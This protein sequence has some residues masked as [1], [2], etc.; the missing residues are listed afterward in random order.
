MRT[1]LLNFSYFFRTGVSILRKRQFILYHKPTT[2]CN[3]RCEFCDFWKNQNTDAKV[4]TEDVIKML[5]DG[6]RAGLTT[7][8]LWG[9]EPLM[10][11]DLG[12]WLM[13]AKKLGYKTSMCTS[14]YLLEERHREI[15]GHIDIILLSLEDVYE[16][17]DKI[18]NT[19][20]LFER[21]IRGLEKFAGD[22]RTK[23][24]I[25]SHINKLNSLSSIDILKFA[26]RF[27]ISVEFFPSNVFSDY[28]EE[29]IFSPEERHETFS[30]IMRLKKQGW[31]V[32][33]SF[34]ALKL[35]RGDRG[36]R[37]NMA[38][39]AIH[40]DADGNITPCETRFISGYSNYGNILSDS[41]SLI[42]KKEL[43][44]ANILSLEK[45]RNCLFPC[46][47]ESANNIYL[48]AGKRFADFI[49][50]KDR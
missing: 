33:N 13:Q 9:G 50:G 45:C 34:E 19:P 17:Q 12:E 30:R 29:I 44:E 10:V 16:R 3:C 25:W 22:K 2:S 27:D 38:R 11:E 26:K 5:E 21:V 37:C 43:Y 8:S 28:N 6:R 36:Y 46:I 49:S 4:K 7:Y 47:A 32:N 42:H 41:L 1:D 31:P 40:V 14:G 15:N 20:G 48:R 35:M 18:R 24:K 23:I 39:N